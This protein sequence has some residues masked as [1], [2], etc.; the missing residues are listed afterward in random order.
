MPSFNTRTVIDAPAERV[1]DV[2]SDVVGWPKWL[3]T[4]TSVHALG[5]EALAVGACYRVAQPKLR[6]AVWSVVELVQ[7]SHFSWESRGPGVRTLASHAMERV[8]HN[9]TR[10]SLRIDYSG[11]LSGLVGLLAGRLTREY[12]EREAAAIKQRAE[13]GAL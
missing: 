10:V 4:V 8:S 13:S 12:I 2:V 9:S 7:Y 1:W 5:T 11:P 6:P 3:P